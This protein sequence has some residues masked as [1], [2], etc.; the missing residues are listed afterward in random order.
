MFHRALR[1][2]ALTLIA[3]APVL[4][5]ARQLPS[6]PP[7]AV[8]DMIDRIFASREFAPRALPAPEWFD[9]GASYLLIE[10]E[11]PA[12]DRMNVVR[13]DSATGARRD[14]L[15][16]AA[17][18]TPA[19]STTPIDIE[20]LAW[21]RDAQRVLVFTNTR[22][23]WRTNSRGDYWL[24]DR[25]SG[26]LKKIGGDA[27]E[28]SLMYAKFSPDASKV[29]YVRANDIYIEELASGATTRLTRD[30][31]DLIINGG[32]DWVNEE[33]LDLHDCYA[34]SPDGSHIAYMTGKYGHSALAV[35]DTKARN[36]VGGVRW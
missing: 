23:V 5:S 11:T 6:A 1:R 35:I 9:G 3:V 8:P 14:V 7:A 13:Y 28:A 16:S 19:G 22:R 25:V 33:E 18:L 29:A 34:W 20:D 17:Q 15:I 31:T 10:P 12:S 2:L 30:G 36:L 27:P 21:S 24:L 32:S 26:R 4:L